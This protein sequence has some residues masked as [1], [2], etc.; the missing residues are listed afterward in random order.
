MSGRRGGR[1]QWRARPA[2]DRVLGPDGAGRWRDDQVQVQRIDGCPGGGRELEVADFGSRRGRGGPVD[3]AE[4]LDQVDGAVVARDDLDVVVLTR[5]DVDAAL[6][7]RRGQGG[8]RTDEAAR[9]RERLGADEAD[10]ERVLQ[11]VR[12]RVR[13]G[14]PRDLE[15]AG[16]LEVDPGRV[17]LVPGEVRLD[18][19][20]PGPL[21]VLVDDGARP[22]VHRTRGRCRWRA[23]PS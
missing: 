1:R 5:P 8:Q 23:S 2:V 11:R 15:L 16:G 17:V 13:A 7:R 3:L 20:E 10:A 19:G 22:C 14:R 12:G 18:A 4:E 21:T 6:L 9:H